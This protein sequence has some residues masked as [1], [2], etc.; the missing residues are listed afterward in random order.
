MNK[1]FVIGC[2]D[3]L[4]S[5]FLKCGGPGGTMGPCPTGQKP[6]SGKTSAQARAETVV[7]NNASERA[8]RRDFGIAKIPAKVMRD[9][10]IAARRAVEAKD[11][12]KAHEH[13]LAA[14]RAHTRAAK[15]HQQNGS[16]PDHRIAE[17]A[18]NQAARIHN[19]VASAVI[20]IGPMDS[21]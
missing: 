4:S 6:V 11:P 15:Y 18:H 8:G 3:R 2:L 16:G 1:T 10:S 19:E 13:H 21:D 9:A 12:F 17:S 5:L 14:S 7:A 20:G